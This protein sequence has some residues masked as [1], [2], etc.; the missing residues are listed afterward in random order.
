VSGRFGYTLP[1][2]GPCL[3]VRPQSRELRC[4]CYYETGCHGGMSIRRWIVAVQMGAREG[5]GETS[6]RAED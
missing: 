4:E 5:M 2:E 3:P 6:K 1:I